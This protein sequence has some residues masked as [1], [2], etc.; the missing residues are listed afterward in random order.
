M[1]KKRKR[2]KK[3]YKV[4]AVRLL[5][6]EG[7]SLSVVTRKLG[8]AFIAPLGKQ[9]AEGKIT[10]FPGKGRLSPEHFE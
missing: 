6:E 4:E 2:Y 3:E 9:V 10:P 1:G 5:V 7:R 8:T